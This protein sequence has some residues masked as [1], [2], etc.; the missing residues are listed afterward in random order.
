MLDKNSSYLITLSGTTNSGKSAVLSSTIDKFK[1]NGAKIIDHL[2][3][4][5][6]DKVAIMEYNNEIIGVCTGGDV[7]KGLLDYWLP[8]LLGKKC[9]YII[10]ATK[11]S[12][13]TCDYIVD[14]ATKNNMVMI[15]LHKF[16]SI[17]KKRDSD[18]AQMIVNL[19]E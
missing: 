16:R 3:D 18:L 19:F 6:K 9:K 7:V 17:G 13:S 8:L 15:P 5:P 1:Q 10:I 14:F 4:G 12:G 11:A 2:K